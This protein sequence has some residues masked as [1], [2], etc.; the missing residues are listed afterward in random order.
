MKAVR[1]VATSAHEKVGVSGRVERMRTG[2]ADGLY[3]QVGRPVTYERF[4]IAA[5]FLAMPYR[6]LLTN[7]T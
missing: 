1:R 5:E 2:I 4:S 3:Q 7:K 6:H